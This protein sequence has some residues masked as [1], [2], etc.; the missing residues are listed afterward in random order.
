M[1]QVK[2][3]FLILL[4]VPT[5]QYAL[6]DNNGQRTPPRP[7]RIEFPETPH[8]RTVT[9]TRM[10]NLLNNYNLATSDNERARALIALEDFGQQLHDDIHAL[11]LLH[12][13]NS[14]MENIR[15]PRQPQQFQ[16][17]VFQRRIQALLAMQAENPVPSL[18]LVRPP[19]LSPEMEAR[20]R[21]AR[22]EANANQQTTQSQQA[23]QEAQRSQEVFGVIG[24]LQIARHS[25]RLREEEQMSRQQE[26]QYN[27]VDTDSA[28]DSEISSILIRGKRLRRQ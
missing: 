9:R 23:L 14:I 7:V 5:I 10:H 26:Q 24:N 4:V 15:N 11:R 8:I 17:N 25:R 28:S 19:E 22:E 16:G 20:I 12:E 3:T 2:I 21:S 13:Y 27:N 6:D 1:N 18:S